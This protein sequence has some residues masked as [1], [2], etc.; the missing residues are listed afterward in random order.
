[1][2]TCLGDSFHR[3]AIQFIVI[4][5]LAGQKTTMCCWCIFR[6]ISRNIYILC[7]NRNVIIVDVIFLVFRLAVFYVFNC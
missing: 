3:L 6:C 4:F 2:Q 5:A 1:M 7:S